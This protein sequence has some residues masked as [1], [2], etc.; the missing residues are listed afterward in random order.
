MSDFVNGMFEL[1]G[2]VMI[3]F[4][5]ARVLRDR[6]VAGVSLLPITFFTSWGF[7]NLYYY[8]SIGQW[9]SFAGGVSVVSANIIW[10][11]LL[12]TYSRPATGGVVPRP[13]IPDNE[14]KYN[15]LPP[16]T[17]S[18]QV[19]AQA[20]WD[21]WPVECALC[22]RESRIKRPTGMNLEDLG[23]PHCGHSNCLEEKPFDDNPAEVE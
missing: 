7:W 16:E 8:P 21:V 15:C 1:F 9:W 20:G 5:I 11:S 3:C 19:S 14:C 13:S 12:W 4:S 2:G 23:C 22:A 17:L 18:Q 6:K 10:L